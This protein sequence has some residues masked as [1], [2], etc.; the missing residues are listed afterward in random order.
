MPADVQTLNSGNVRNLTTPPIRRRDF[1][2]RRPGV[3][4]AAIATVA[5]FPIA[6]HS[7]AQTLQWQPVVEISATAEAFLRERTGSFDSN[8]TVQASSIDSRHRLARCS[9]PLEAFL[10]SGTEI[11]AR[12]I[13]GVRCSGTKPWKVYVPVDVVVTASVLVARQSLPKGHVLTA[14]DLTAEQRDVSRQR[15]GYLSDLHRVV[16]QRLKTQL[17]AGK[18]LLP[19]M[20]QA[21]IAIRRGQ[22]VTLIVGTGSFKISVSGTAMNDGVLNQRI[23]VR[24]TNSGRVIEGVVRSREH[25]EV[26]LSSNSSFFHAKPKVSAQMADTR[27]SNNDR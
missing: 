5:L 26:L 25:V 3:A 8:T 21:D 13:V 19:S 24:N 17:I 15:N 4:L 12:T 20:L 18:I 22:S 11:K 1:A 9:K 7:Q 23:R 10:R 16:G 2:A 27:S 6:V 14:A